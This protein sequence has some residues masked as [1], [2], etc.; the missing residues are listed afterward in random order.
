ML[1]DNIAVEP[2]PLVDAQHAVD[3]P[4]H[5]ADDPADHGADRPGRAFAIPRASLNPAG[6][7]LGLGQR[8]QRQTGGNDS[9]SNKTAK[10]DYFPDLR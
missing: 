2:R 1:L 10:H 5:A 8:G 7:P 6:N 9:H 4:N 3:A